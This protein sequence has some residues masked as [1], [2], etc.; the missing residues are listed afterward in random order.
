M[1][2]GLTGGIASG[3][4][5]VA[6][7]FRQLGI[8][9]ASAD[10]ISRSLT[11]PNQPTW[12]AIV[13]RF[14][15]DILQAD[16]QIDRAALRQLVFS[17]PEAKHDLETILHPLIKEALEDWHRQ[18]TSLFQVLEIPLLFETNSQTMVDRILV[19]DCSPE[20][21]KSRLKERDN[22]SDDE[23]NAILAQQYSRHQRLAQA[24]DIIV[25]DADIEHL[26]AQIEQ[27]VATYRQLDTASKSL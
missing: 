14:G 22:L 16:Q 3:K 4:S 27:L 21:Q 19:V 11:V 15:D 2:I 26:Q 1:L 9:V 13:D 18:Q 23:V 5:T 20:L 8:P 12:Q 10:E 25:N 7:M 6:N 24:D 17:D